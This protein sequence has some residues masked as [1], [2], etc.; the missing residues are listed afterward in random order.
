MDAD[1]FARVTYPILFNPPAFGTEYRNAR[2]EYVP[3]K[4]THPVED[5]RYPA[6]A[7]VANDARFGTDYRP[8][9]TQNTPAGS[10]FM[11]KQWLMHNSQEIV[12]LS[13]RRQSEWTGATLPMANTMPPP[14]TIVH[15]TPFDN[16]LQPSG[17]R[18]GIGVERADAKA[19]ILFG[20]FQIPPTR[21]EIMANSKRIALTKKY[22]GGRNSTRGGSISNIKLYR[23][24]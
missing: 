6:Y 14:E 24:I 17:A 5:N 8:K 18:N 21:E 7:G 15:S 2:R 22:E 9:C 12:E 16:E 19:P 11:T 13:R 20:T 4:F 3:P 1:G 23:D 10:Q